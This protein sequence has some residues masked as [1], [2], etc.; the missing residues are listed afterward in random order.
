MAEKKMCQKPAEWLRIWPGREP[1]MV[2]SD[3][4]E[5]TRK[6]SEALGM[7]PPLKKFADLESGLV[8]ACTEGRVQEVRI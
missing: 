4:A 7:Q 6:V 1:D 5:D 3:H 8:C 2:C